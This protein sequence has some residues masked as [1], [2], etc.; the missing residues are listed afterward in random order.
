MA[1]L[2]ACELN[3][4]AAAA[5]PLAADLH[6]HLQAA[7]LALLGAHD[8]A[9]AGWLHD[10]PRDKPYTVGPLLCDGLYLPAGQPLTA[11]QALRWRLTA[12][13]EPVAAALRAIAQTPPSHLRLGEAT[14]MVTG[15]ALAARGDY[16][17][18]CQRWLAGPRPVARLRFEFVGPAS[19]RRRGPSG[20]TIPLLWPEPG[21]LFERLAQ[22]WRHAAP[23]ELAEALPLPA[24]APAHL[25]V[26]S[27]GSLTITVQARRMPCF[28]GRFEYAPDDGL[29]PE[30]LGL[31]TEFA[32]FAGLGARTTAGL[33]AVRTTV[34]GARSRGR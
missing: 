21:L 2:L 22:R 5:G 3:L 13:D 7:A 8:A 25:L 19:F 6:D 9:L 18:L 15:A 28:S 31:L 1:H 33:G 4:R 29:S 27:G 24:F 11:D 20:R 17:E 12:L 10:L 30:V 32:P 16:A 34:L 26:W 14:L 23:S